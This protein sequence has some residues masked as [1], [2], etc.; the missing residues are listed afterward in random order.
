[1]TYYEIPIENIEPSFDLSI[2]ILEKEYILEFSWNNEG[3]FWNI[4]MFTSDKT[5]IFLGRK[6]VLNYDLFSY[7][8][9]PLLPQGKLRAVDESN[10]LKE[11]DFDDLGN[12]VKLIYEL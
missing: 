1:M 2:D 11:C 4:S 5:P 10:T 7:C 8:S 12:R 9:N 6:L 3:E